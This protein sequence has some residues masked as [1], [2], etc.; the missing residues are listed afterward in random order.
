M[1][2]RPCF[3][4]LLAIVNSI[5]GESTQSFKDAVT[6]IAQE[7]MSK[8][9]ATDDDF[10]NV[11][12]R[13]RLET[14]TAKVTYYMLYRGVEACSDL[15]PLILFLPCLRFGIYP[16]NSNTFVPAS[17]LISSEALGQSSSQNLSRTF[18]LLNISRD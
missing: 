11:L 4:C 8:V 13:N 15:P 9:E 7:C 1:R 17:F 12:H 6:P 16:Q 10:Q 2:Y 3:I 14:R 18:N 5:L